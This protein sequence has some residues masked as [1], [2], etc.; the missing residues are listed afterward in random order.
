MTCLI[1]KCKIQPVY[2]PIAAVNWRILTGGRSKLPAV[3]E[4]YNDR[5][6]LDEQS[7]Y[8]ELFY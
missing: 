1:V 2:C 3:I 8:R 5:S 7:D 4:K 6:D